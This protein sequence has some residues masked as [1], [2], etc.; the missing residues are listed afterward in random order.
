MGEKRER[1]KGK[2]KKKVKERGRVSAEK[3]EQWERYGGGT[4]GRRQVGK[5]IGREEEKQGRGR[6]GQKGED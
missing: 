6:L 2:E 4:E 1:E 3:R 5:E